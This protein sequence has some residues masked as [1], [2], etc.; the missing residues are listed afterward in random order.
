LSGY[1]KG[2]E[3]AVGEKGVNLSGGQK[4]RIQLARAVYSDKDIYILGILIH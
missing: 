4:A 3:T 1:F 2:D